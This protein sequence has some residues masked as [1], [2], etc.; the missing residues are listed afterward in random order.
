MTFTVKGFETKLLNVHYTS[1]GFSGGCESF[2]GLNTIEIIK[3]MEAISV[4][5]AQSGCAMRPGLNTY[6]S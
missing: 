4:S 1:M 2:D 3:P 6:G 5:L